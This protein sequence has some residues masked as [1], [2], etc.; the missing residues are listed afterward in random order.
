M[1]SCLHSLPRATPSY[2][3]PVEP[4]ICPFFSEDRV[5]ATMT[6]HDVL[7]SLLSKSNIQPSVIKSMFSH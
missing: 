5:K 2:K 3:P 1:L 4:P 7:S 6:P